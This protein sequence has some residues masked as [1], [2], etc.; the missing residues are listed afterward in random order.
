MQL[1]EVSSC[2]TDEDVYISDQCSPVIQNWIALADHTTVSTGYKVNCS[3]ATVC[4]Y[5]LDSCQAF[6]L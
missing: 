5:V 3:N 1:K 2:T 4:I 6:I